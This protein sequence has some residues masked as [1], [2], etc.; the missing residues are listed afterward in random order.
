MKPRGHEILEHPADVGISAHG[1]TLQEAFEE[2]ARGL[3][4][5]ILDPATIHPT[6]AR[7]VSV[8]ASDHEQLLVRWLSEVLYLYDGRRFPCAEFSIHELG[9]T[10]LVA[11]VRG[12]E[13]DTS[14]HQTR[15][16]V[17]AVTYHQLEVR[18]APGR[19]VVRVFLDI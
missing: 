13:L 9:P 17:K 8:T 14:R 18:E 11:T 15:L 7:T 16:D 3:M 2:A 4:A 19:A 5:V 10:W 6:T 1:E 12:E